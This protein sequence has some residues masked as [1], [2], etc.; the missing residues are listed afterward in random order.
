MGS[1]VQLQ[2]LLE[3]LIGS[4]NV[5]FQPPETVK[6]QY[7]CIIYE[8]NKSE[9]LYA[10]N[11][12]YANKF[13]YQLTLIDPNPDSLLIDKVLC[14]PLC[15]FERHYVADNLNHDVYNLYY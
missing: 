15:S 12:P 7:P 13:R 2:T 5:Y 8:R 10:D 1:R 6:L 4:R 11:A 14:L 9:T 3:S